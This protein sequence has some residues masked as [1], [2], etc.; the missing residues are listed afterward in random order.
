MRGTVE[1]PEGL[2]YLHCFLDPAEERDLCRRL[3]D[4][5]YAEVRM[6]GQVA[7]R[8]VRHFG[9]DYE[10]ESAGVT[11]GEPVPEWLNPVRK[12]CAALL[13]L[14]GVVLAEV[15]VT[16]YPPGAGIGWHRDAPAFGDVV[17]VSLGSGCVMRFQR[18][19]GEHRRVYEQPLEPRSAYLLSGPSHSVWQ[20]SIPAVTTERYSL[21]F[22]TLR[23]KV[24]G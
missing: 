12:R 3:S 2:R 8:Q 23:W 5:E 18:D 19:T 17:G 22:R 20:H 10:Y 15:L 21:T 4:L 1:R 9:I 11:V 13:D 6:R 24:R 16:H 7:R 14:P